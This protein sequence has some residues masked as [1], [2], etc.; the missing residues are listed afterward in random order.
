MWDFKHEISGSGQRCQLLKSLSLVPFLLPPP[1]PGSYCLIYTFPPIKKRP[2]PSPDCQG[3]LS[4]KPEVPAACRAGLPWLPGANHLI[5]QATQSMWSSIWPKGVK[6][7]GMFCYSVFIVHT[8]WPQHHLAVDTTPTSKAHSQSLA[9]T[10]FKDCKYSYSIIKDDLEI[11]LGLNTQP[12]QSVE[13]NLWFPD[14]SILTLKSCNSKEL[15]QK[16]G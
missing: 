11:A 9:E 8:A 12:V 4:P 3:K 2:Q 7:P 6:C 15:Y 5:A 14:L 1:F 13:L 16:V 10:S